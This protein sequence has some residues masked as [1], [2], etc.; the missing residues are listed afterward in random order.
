MTLSAFAQADDPTVVF[1]ARMKADGSVLLLA[2]DHF[3][4]TNGPS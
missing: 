4:T 1:D 2:R 3:G